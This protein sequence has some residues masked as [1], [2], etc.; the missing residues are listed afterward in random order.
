MTHQMFRDRSMQGGAAVQ[1]YVAAVSRGLPPADEAAAA[2]RT[3][4]A[5]TAVLQRTLDVGQLLNLF[6]G[7][8]RKT[9]PH[10]SVAYRHETHGIR[11]L[12]GKAAH[13]SCTYNLTVEDETLGEIA[14]TRRMR[15]SAEELTLLEYLL[16]SLVYPL[17]NAIDYKKVTDQAHRDPL[18]GVYNRGVLEATLRRET[19]LAKRH[20]APFSLTSIASR[21]STT[22]SVTPPATASSAASSRASSVICAR[23]ICSRATAA[24][25]SCWC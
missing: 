1:G 4:L 11:I 23:P 19:A 25:S 16:C 24:T 7:E 9:V 22:G 14:F 10:D 2:H 21:T 17:R 5:I 3:A 12:Q 20:Q 18:T 13:H 8:L 6:T 15:F